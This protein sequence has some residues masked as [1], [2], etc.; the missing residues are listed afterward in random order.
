MKGVVWMG[1]NS[2]CCCNAIEE[3]GKKK[4]Q[5]ST[6]FFKCLDYKMPLDKKISLKPPASPRVLESVPE[7]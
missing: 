3:K 5:V 4:R 1:E 7:E 6:S 2:I